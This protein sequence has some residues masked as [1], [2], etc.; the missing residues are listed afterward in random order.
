MLIDHHLHRRIDQALDGFRVV[1]VHGPRQSGKTTLARLITEMRGGTYPTLDNDATREAALADPITFLAEHQGLLTVDEIQLGGDRV[2]RAIKQLVDADTTPGRFLLTGSTNFLT[3]PTISESLAGRVRILGLW[4][5]SEAEILGR[6]PCLFDQ[7]FNRP[8]RI[9]PGE[10]TERRRY[11]EVL[12][13]GGY[14][15]IMSL[16]PHL[17]D[18]WYDSYID[19]VTRRDLFE[20]ADIRRKAAFPSLLRWVAAATATEIN[21]TTAA[22]DLGIDRSTVVSYLEWLRTV[23]LIHE[24]PP[25]SRNFTSRAVRRSKLHV[26]DTGLAANLSGIGPAMLAPAT[27]LATGP[28]LETFT[29]NEISR[30]LTALGSRVGMFHY[31]DHQKREIDLILERR[32]GAV[33]AVEIKATSSPSSGHLRHVRWLRD[34]LDSA[35]PG[36]F[37]AGVLLHTGPQSLTV[38]DRLYLR[39]ISMLW[40]AAN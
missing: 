28:L 34:K 6:P 36:T 13:R 29:V 18:D 11:L 38:G 17:R 9:G 15:E 25:W 21:V 35:A 39:P 7:W 31:R 2:V 16:D 8:T 14:P 5:L 27:A 37:R 30:Q 3:V 24:L 40:S 22:N 23:F 12:C 26:T 19:T 33:V 20:L 1:M 4:P 32:D 10:P